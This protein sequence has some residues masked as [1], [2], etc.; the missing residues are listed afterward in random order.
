MFG[1]IKNKIFGNLRNLA[2]KKASSLVNFI[3]KGGRELLENP[4]SN[5]SGY[6]QDWYFQLP[7]N[8]YDSAFP[9]MNSR[10]CSWQPP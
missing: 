3:E 8:L 7:D 5:R 4:E 1:G 10:S 2:I 6:I 9:R